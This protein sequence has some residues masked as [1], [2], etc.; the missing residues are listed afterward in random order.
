M[1]KEEA[2]PPVLNKLSKDYRIFHATCK[3]LIGKA[4]RITVKRLFT[5]GIGGEATP[6]PYKMRRKGYHNRIT[7]VKVMAGSSL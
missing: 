3:L 7:V 1:P 6:L 4:E 5:G 2:F